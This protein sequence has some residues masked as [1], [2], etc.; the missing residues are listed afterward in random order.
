MLG[1]TIRKQCTFLKKLSGKNVIREDHWQSCGPRASI[2]PKQKKDAEAS[3]F[4][5]AGTGLEPV[6]AAAD[7]S[8][9]LQAIN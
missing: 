3:S 1:C 5:V 8:P 4:N 7:M 2:R 6:S 9:K